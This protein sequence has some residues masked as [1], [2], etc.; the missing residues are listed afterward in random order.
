MINGEMFIAVVGLGD[1]VINQGKRF[2]AAGV[3]AVLLVI[4]V[5][6]L[7][8]V[9]LVQIVDRR[10]TVWVPSTARQKR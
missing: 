2:D 8:A 7:F 9:K 6:S 3:L 5:V 4:V 10:L 1:V